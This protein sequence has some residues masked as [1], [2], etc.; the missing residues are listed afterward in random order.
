MHQ[1]EF[2]A[3]ITALSLSAEDLSA[4]ARTDVVTARR[5][6]AGKSKPRGVLAAT[7]VAMAGAYAA[8]R[9]KHFTITTATGAH[10][11]VE[12]EPRCSAEAIRQLRIMGWTFTGCDRNGTTHY[13]RPTKAVAAE[14]L[15]RT[16]VA[17]D[18]AQRDFEEAQHRLDAAAQTR[19]VLLHAL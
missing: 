17:V 11:T 10:A 9:S 7:V 12:I 14:S 13:F 5:W 18:K 3:Q 6:L 19:L 16:Q 2:S 4:A 8:A 1:A 15:A